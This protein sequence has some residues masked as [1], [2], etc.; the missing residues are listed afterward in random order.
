[1]LLFIKILL[2]NI[3]DMNEELQNI[4]P[5]S[6]ND[7]GTQ[8]EYVQVIKKSKRSYDDESHQSELLHYKKN[9]S[10]DIDNI[11]ESSSPSTSAST[12]SVVKDLSESSDIILEQQIREKAKDHIKELLDIVLFKDCH[13]GHI[14]HLSNELSIFFNSK[15][16]NVNDII[17]YINDFVNKKDSIIDIGSDYVYYNDSDS[18]KLNFVKIY[19]IDNPSK[20]TQ[21]LSYK[22]LRKLYKHY[23]QSEYNNQNYKLIQL[24]SITVCKYTKLEYIDITVSKRIIDKK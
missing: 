24:L 23:R 17:F 3:L 15:N 10:S 18:K 21:I 9:K 7:V 4:V 5:L 13:S 22:N 14:L 12:S 20:G 19:F 11:L 6:R 16:Y 1:M 8:T 2:F